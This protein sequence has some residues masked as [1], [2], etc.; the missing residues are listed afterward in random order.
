M[1]AQT[2][3]KTH[4]ITV[5]VKVLFEVTGQELNRG[6]MAEALTVLNIL[7]ESKG[8]LVLFLEQ[9]TLHFLVAM[10]HRL[11]VCVPVQFIC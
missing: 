1:E 4:K 2:L 5:F 3:K 9:V 6:T 7:A 10:C 11:Y 8:L